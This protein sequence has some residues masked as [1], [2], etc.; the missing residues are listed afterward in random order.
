MILANLL[1]GTH[2]FGAWQDDEGQG[3][4]FEIKEVLTGWKEELF[5]HEN[6]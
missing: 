1:T 2:G 4:C 6:S 3:T 5:P